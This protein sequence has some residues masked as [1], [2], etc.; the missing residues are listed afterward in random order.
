VEVLVT[1]EAEE[2]TVALGHRLDTRRRQIVAAAHERG[3]GA[4]LEPAVALAE[5]GDEEDVA[6]HRG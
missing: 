3:R 5:R 6:V 4:V 2:R 1:R